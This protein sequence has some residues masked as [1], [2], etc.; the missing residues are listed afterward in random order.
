MGGVLTPLQL[1]NLLQQCADNAISWM[2]RQTPISNN[3]HVSV[4]YVTA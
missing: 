2:K 3:G 1:I 4:L